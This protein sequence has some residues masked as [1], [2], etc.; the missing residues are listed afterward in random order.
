MSTLRF[1]FDF[2]SPYAYL[3]WVQIQSLAEYHQLQLEPVPVLFAAMLDEFGHK[4]P[5]EIEPKRRYTFKHVARLAHD[6]GVP[7]QPPPAHPFNPLLALRVAGSTRTDDERHATIEVLYRMAWASGQGVTD[8]AAV[9]EALSVAG[10]PGSELV[11]RAQS[12]EAKAQ[13]RQQTEQAIGRGV[14]GVPSMEVEG[15]D[16]VFWGQ[17]SLLHLNRFI[18]GGDPMS[19]G[20]RERLENLP[21]GTDRKGV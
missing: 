7:L 16:E 10:L 18:E 2:I 17:D 13:L 5:A 14:F 3:G 4:G 20:L 9:T 12:P 6:L 21:R 15:T 8:E 19:P 11:A 1:Y